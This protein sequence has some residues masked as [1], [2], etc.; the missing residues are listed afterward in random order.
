M[1]TVEVVPVQQTA[2]VEEKVEIVQPIKVEEAVVDAAP[3]E[4]KPADD[5]KEADAADSVAV[6]VEAETVTVTETEEQPPVEEPAKA[7][8]EAGDDEKKVGEETEEKKAEVTETT[9]GA[10]EPEEDEKQAETEPKE[11]ADE[12]VE[13]TE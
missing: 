4:D 13:K 3:L 12:A 5:Q 8:E 10:A 7:V 11:E 1:A 2:F 9:K 6:E